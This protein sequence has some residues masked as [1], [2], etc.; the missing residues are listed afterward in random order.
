MSDIVIEDPLN[1]H[2]SWEAL[3]QDITPIG[4]SEGYYQIEDYLI[5]YPG[6]EANPR[7]A[8]VIRSKSI[9]TSPQ[10]GR[11]SAG[12]VN[13][14]G[15]AWSR[16]NKQ[17]SVELH[18][19]GPDGDRNLSA[20]LGPYLGPFAWRSFSAS[21]TLAPGA[22]T[23]RSFC[24]AG[25]ERLEAPWNNQGYENSSAHAVTFEIVGP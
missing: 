3:E 22:Y 23:V 6:S 20:E 17:L 7:P 14:R 5:V 24:Q 19:S 2:I 8:T 12:Q 18:L 15:K 16:D 25:D 11:R 10:E 21:A 13:F 1:R 4:A 9:L